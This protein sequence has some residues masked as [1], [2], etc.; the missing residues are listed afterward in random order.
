MSSQ[1]APP[2]TWADADTVTHGARWIWGLTR[3]DVTQMNS[4]CADFSGANRCA[5]IVNAQL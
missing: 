5:Y 4:S 3:N 2:L 1:V